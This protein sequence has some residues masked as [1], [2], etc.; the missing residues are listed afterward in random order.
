ML[1]HPY[2]Q[3][4]HFESLLLRVR[5]RIKQ[6]VVESITMR[7]VSMPY[8]LKNA[9][10]I[11][12][13]LECIRQRW[14]ET[15]DQVDDQSSPVFILSAGW[16]SGSTLM[17]RL[18][19][20]SGEITIWGE[21]LGDTGLIQRLGAAIANISYKFPDDSYI[22][23]GKSLSGL[24]NKWIANLTPPISYLRSSHR[25]LLEEWLG[26]PAKEIHGAPRW[27]LKEV[28]L[29]IDHARYLNWLFP[30]ARF[31]FIYRDLF[32]AYKSWRGN[33]WGS[34]W[35]GYFSWS[36]IAFARHWRFLVEGYL[37]GYK[38]VD[39]ILVKFEDLISGKVDID[40]LASHIGVKKID[41]SVLDKKIGAPEARKK[42]RKKV[43]TPVERMI[44]SAIAGP[45]LAQLGYKK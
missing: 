33:T 1:A 11:S 28:R 13:A 38:D 41:S 14:P 40:W 25:A 4:K 36:P 32:D 19:V 20:S 8:E 26:R 29:T 43:I 18:V 6:I 7:K 21:P 24:S 44:L 9:N 30:N 16:R 37:S 45:V 10:K 39:G 35:P 5:E 3:E 27:G 17:Q 12:V 2:Q 22:D 23:E 34:V 15:F 42:K 31:I